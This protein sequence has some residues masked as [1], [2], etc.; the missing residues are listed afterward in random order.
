MNSIKPRKLGMHA[1]QAAWYLQEGTSQPA[2]RKH[3]FIQMGKP[4]EAL[5]LVDM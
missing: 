2:K 4:L 3:D 1:V 5:K